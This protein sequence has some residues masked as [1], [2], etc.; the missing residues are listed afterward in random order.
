VPQTIDPEWARERLLW[1]I[2]TAERARRKLTTGVA[3]VADVRS[4]SEL[5][6][7][8]HQLR[9]VLAV[10]RER[11]T[12]GPLLAATRDGRFVEVQSGINLVRFAL[13]KLQSDEETRRHITGSTAPTMAA[14]ALHEDIWRAASTLW[15][16]G[17]YAEAVQR[18]A[19]FLNAEVQSRVGRTDVSDRDLMAQAF[20][21]APPELGKP[22]LR[23]RGDDTDLTVKAMRTGLLSFSQGVFAAI[24]NPATHS[25]DELPKQIALEQLV[26]LSTLARW[27]DR[28]E[29]VTA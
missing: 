23:W 1:W 11:P 13:G 2:K 9:A 20:S 5:R 12:A 28:C 10:I 6:E 18:A 14:D 7:H 21:T 17:H 25:T 8:E 26:T 4:T 16:D 29:L 19:T 27:I 24:R 22:R 15:S 3:S